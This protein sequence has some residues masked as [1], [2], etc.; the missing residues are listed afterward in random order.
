MTLRCPGL[1]EYQHPKACWPNGNF[2]PDLHMVLLDAIQC[3]QS[4]E[5]RCKKILALKLDL[6]DLRRIFAIDLIALKTSS[7]YVAN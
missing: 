6:H 4:S 7:A 5:L 2:K 3:V 1:R